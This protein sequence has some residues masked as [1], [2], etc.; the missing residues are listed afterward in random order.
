MEFRELVYF[1]TVTQKESISK[2]AEALYITQPNLSRQMQ[3]LETEIGQKLFIRGNRKITLTETGKLLKKRA[4]EIIE[5]MEKTKSE[6]F[7]KD[8]E[9]S[10]TLYIGGGESYAVKLIA[11][12]VKKLQSDYSKIKFRFFSGD[13]NEVIEKLDKGLI[14]FGILIEPADLSKYNYF[15]LP[16]SDSWGVLMR[17]DSPLAKKSFI[18]PEDLYSLPLIFSVHS[19]NEY[20]I[21]DWLNKKTEQLNIVATYNLIYNASLMVQEGLGYAIALDKLINTSGKSSLRFRPLYPEIKSDLYLVWKKNS[22]LSK[23]SKIF[24]DYF[25]KIVNSTD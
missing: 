2:A 8:N 9:I 25:K 4:E 21:T 23:I 24:L 14:D 3:Q 16:L 11:Q 6:L 17:K 12:T 20:I 22:E 7:L 18:S 15:R 13:T 19:L 1:V 10:G 5:L